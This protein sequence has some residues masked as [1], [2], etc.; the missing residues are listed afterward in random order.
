MKRLLFVAISAVAS[1]G[2]VHAEIFINIPDA[3]QISYQTWPDGKIYL[4][5]LNAFDPN[6]QGCCWSYFIDTTSTEGKNIFALL[7]ALSAQGRGMQLGLPDGYASGP[8]NY[9]TK[10]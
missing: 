10:L 8:V 5:N 2:T 6:A 3:S 4:R 9:G 7:L 1:L